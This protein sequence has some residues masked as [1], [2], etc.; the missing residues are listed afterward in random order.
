V[1][2]RRLPGGW[3]IVMDDIA[4]GFWGAAVL[5]VLRVTGVLG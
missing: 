5:A 1:A 3:G 2:E 4:A